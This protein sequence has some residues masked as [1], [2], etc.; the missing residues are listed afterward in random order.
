MVNRPLHQP[1]T[2][3]RVRYAQKDQ[4][5]VELFLLPNAASSIPLQNGMT[6]QVEIAIE[7]LSPA[8]LVLRSSGQLLDTLP[9]SIDPQ[10]RSD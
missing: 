1:Q 2:T 8:T 5:Q 4:L 7:H 3:R 10:D 9:V 6:G